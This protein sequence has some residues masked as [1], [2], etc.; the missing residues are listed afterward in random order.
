MADSFVRSVVSNLLGRTTDLPI[1]EVNFLYGEANQGRS[2][3]DE[4]GWIHDFL[5]YADAVRLEEGDERLQDLLSQF[6]DIVYDAEDVID[7]IILNVASVR[8]RGGFRGLVARIFNEPKQRHRVVVR[9]EAI[10]SRI[11]EI[12]E[13]YPTYGVQNIAGTS[14]TNRQPRDGWTRN[15]AH[16]EED[17]VGLDQD[18]ENL[19]AKL[20]N[21]EGCSRIVSIVGMGGSGKTTLAKKLFNLVDIKKHFD[22]HAW[23]SVSQEWQVRYLLINI[24]TQTTSPSKKDRKLIQEMDIGELVQKVHDFLKKKRYLLVLDDVWENE[25]WDKLRPAFP[26]ENVG[27]KLII[28]TRIQ[29][30]ALHVDPNCYV[31]KQRSLTDEEAWEL[32]FKKVKGVIQNVGRGEASHFHELGKEM[33]KKCCG[34]PLAIVVLGGLLAK[35]KFLVDWEKVSESIGWQLR[36]PDKGHMF[37]VFEVLALSYDNL[38]YYLKPCFLYLGMFPKDTKIRVKPLIRMWIAE[39]FISSPQIVGEETLEQTGEEYLQELIRRS[40]I[41]VVEKDGTGRPKSCLMHDLLRHLCLDKAREERFLEVLSSSWS[42]NATATEGSLSKAR[43]IAV[44]FG[45]Y[46]DFSKCSLLG[47]KNSCIRS[48]LCFG[49]ALYISESEWKTLCTNLPL[50]RVIHLEGVYTSFPD[51]RLQKQ[52]KNLFH[53]KYFY[54]EYFRKDERETASGQYTPEL[55]REE[56]KPQDLQVEN[57]AEVFSRTIYQW[58]GTCEIEE[59]PCSSESPSSGSGSDQ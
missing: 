51:E 29:N 3:R 56:D 40:L 32:L 45:D 20:T 18:V 59:V 58:G 23:V 50:I 19:L 22:C 4:L 15:Y 30:V 38:P 9:F 13:M 44:H 17:V 31:H 33:V 8:N 10:N 24:I 36:Q 52:I 26:S 27:S 14:T 28:T 16:E 49:S 21:K 57:G 5:K 48:L 7:I 1:D 54:I 53:L 25:A 41:Q 42:T 47:L 35:K 55:E 39:G 11:S 43:R 46:A 12:R 2:L 6:R 37:V 34:L